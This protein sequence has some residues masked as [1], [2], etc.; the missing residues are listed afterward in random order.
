MAGIDQDDVIQILRMLEE[1]TFDELHLEMGDL[2]LVA[3]K[4]SK[5]AGLVEGSKP[6]DHELTESKAAV[7]PTV[8]AEAKKPHIPQPSDLEADGLIA[9]KAPMLGTFYRA[10]KPGAP[11]FVEIG[12]EVSSDDS[13]CIIEVMKLFNTVKANVRGRIAKICAENGQMVEYQ[14]TLFL[15]EALGDSTEAGE[16]EKDS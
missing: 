12:R 7:A 15:V 9:I 13:V 3:S 16:G 2:K 5:R 1:S 11:P 4:G 6:D 10:P 8:R 14:Q